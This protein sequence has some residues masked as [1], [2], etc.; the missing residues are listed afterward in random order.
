MRSPFFRPG[1]L[2]SIA[3]TGACGALLSSHLA[4]AGQE[5][6][7]AALPAYELLDANACKMPQARPPKPFAAT[8]ARY[9]VER[10]FLDIDGSGQCVLMDFW[11]ARV[12]GSA[13]PGMRTLEHRFLRVVKGRWQAF[14]T[15]LAYFPHVLKSASDARVY[16]IEAPVEAD[17][18]DALVLA[19]QVPRV[20]S[21]AGW[22]ADSPRMG[23]TLALD[24]AEDQRAR[25]LPALAALL[26]QRYDPAADPH[27][28]LRARIA[29]LRREANQ[30]PP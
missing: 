30:A 1:R 28:A 11:I 26:E 12:G 17:T 29:L 27:G 2:L 8:Y 15:E 6:G 9:H 19:F 24:S 5:P 4:A 18:D 20:F 25:L 7:A 3:L 22:T 16:L 14:E 21:P 23:A 10:R 13:S